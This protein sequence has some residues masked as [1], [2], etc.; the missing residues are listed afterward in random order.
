MSED[1]KT[2]QER[3]DRLVWVDLETTGLDDHVE[4]EA[5]LQFGI[6]VTDLDLNIID[7]Q[8]VL[9]WEQ[10]QASCWAKADPYV[11][12]MHT[13][14]GLIEKAEKHGIPWLGAKH[15]MDEWL[16]AFGLDGKK[17]PM[18][19]S[20]IQFD[21]NFLKHYAPNFLLRHFSYRNI[22]VSSFKETFAHFRPELNEE[23]DAAYVHDEKAHSVLDDIEDSIAEY[24]FYLTKTG[25]L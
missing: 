7:A 25:I 13:K 2:K 10:W 14:S 23:R 15:H 4:Q 1:R 16:G 22:D 17:S 20:S 9:V 12:D 3:N 8:S 24:K 11:R 18:C 6:A 19:G 5:I 21:R